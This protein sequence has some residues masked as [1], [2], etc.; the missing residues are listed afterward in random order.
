MHLK[1]DKQVMEAELKTQCLLRVSVSVSVCVCVC[2]CVRA[3]ARTRARVFVGKCLWYVLVGMWFVFVG[4]RA[5]SCV[6]LRVCEQVCLYMCS[7]PC[8]LF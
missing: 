6:Y 3:R 2:V 1:F 5:P 8:P 7:T 4:V